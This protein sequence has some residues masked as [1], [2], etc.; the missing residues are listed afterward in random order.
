MST[1]YKVR[2][3]PISVAAPITFS[4]IQEDGSV[5]DVEITFRIKRLPE[6]DIEALSAAHPAPEDETLAK[7]LDR[8]AKIFGAV[9]TDWDVLDADASEAAQKDVVQPFS[10]EALADLIT[11]EDGLTI[12]NKLN[13]AWRNLRFNLIAGAAKNSQPSPEPTSTAA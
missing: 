9:V 4:Q 7:M 12:S 1:R 5:Q 2:K 13:E 3:T 8:N 11:G 6:K 10:Q